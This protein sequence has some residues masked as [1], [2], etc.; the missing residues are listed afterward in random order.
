MGGFD[1]PLKNFNAEEILYYC[2]AI[3]AIATFGSGFSNLF[4]KSFGHP[5]SDDVFDFNPIT[6]LDIVGT[7]CRHNKTTSPFVPQFLQVCFQPI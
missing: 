4:A 5:R 1:L 7:I 2:V 6:N 3:L